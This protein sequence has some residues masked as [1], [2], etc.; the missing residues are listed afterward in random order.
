LF[1][2]DE[3][4]QKIGDVQVGALGAVAI[5]DAKYNSF[6]REVFRFKRNI[7]DAREL[8]HSEIRG[9]H[10]FTKAVF[11]R[12]A[13]HG[14]SHWLMAVDA[15]FVA[16]KNHGAQTFA[17]WTDAPDHVDLRN[18]DPASLSD[19]YKKLLY[20]FRHLM[21]TTAGGGLGSLNFDQRSYR[22]DETAACAIQN[23]IVRTHL[24]G[25]W[26]RLFIQV[27]SFTVSAVSPGLQAADVV[28]HLAA[29]LA[30]PEFRPELQPYVAKAVALA[31]VAGTRT[32]P[33]PCVSYIATGEG[34][35]KKRAKRV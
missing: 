30:D 2:I 34:G 25:Q 10:A 8:N 14:D 35:P 22:E 26:R 24:R 12:Q 13:L 5:E 23:Y 11:R 33:E 19:T 27:P 6:C 4:W 21:R 1:F 32:R 17:V 31:H 29:H 20:D 3:S 9:Q 18:S 28:A 15:L 7:L 16:L